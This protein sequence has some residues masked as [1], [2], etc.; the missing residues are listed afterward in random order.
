MNDRTLRMS[1]NSLT[2]TK[3][4]SGPSPMV[5]EKARLFCEVESYIT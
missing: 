2:L 3:V 1:C 4:E 5:K